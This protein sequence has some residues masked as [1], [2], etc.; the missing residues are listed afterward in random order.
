MT[1]RRLPGI[2][3]ILGIPAS[4]VTIMRPLPPAGQ[5]T[6]DQ[7]VGVGARLQETMPYRLLA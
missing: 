2:D 5:V 1:M 4:I 7:L 3:L 6:A